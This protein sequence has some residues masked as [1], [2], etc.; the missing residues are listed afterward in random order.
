[1]EEVVGHEDVDQL[2]GNDIDNDVRAVEVFHEVV[3]VLVLPQQ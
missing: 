2:E 1:M 3:N